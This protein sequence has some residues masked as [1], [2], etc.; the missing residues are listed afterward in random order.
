MERRT[1]TSSSSD[2]VS[3]KA[4]LKFVSEANPAL[5]FSIVRATFILVFANL[6][7]AFSKKITTL[8]KFDFL[9]SRID[10]A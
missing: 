2:T 5:V 7:A 1:T 8:F 6:L 4:G 9:R 10:F 3:L